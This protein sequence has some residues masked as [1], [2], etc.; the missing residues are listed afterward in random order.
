M[1]AHPTQPTL[2]PQTADIRFDIKSPVFTP[3]PG[4]GGQIKKWLSHHFA[5]KILPV[6][7]LG[8][9]VLGIYM[10]SR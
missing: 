6:I 4:W 8:T 5:S 2:L 7:S 10:T 1:T 9:L 3:E